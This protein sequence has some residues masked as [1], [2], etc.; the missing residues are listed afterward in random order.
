MDHV[1][2]TPEIVADLVSE[3][4]GTV[5]V[6]G[7]V[8]RCGTGKTLSL[9]RWMAEA[10]AQGSLRVAY[11]D[12]HTLLASDKVEID[13]GGQVRGAAVGHYPMFDLNGADV[14]IVDEPL[15]NRELV[16]R[17]LAHVEPDGGAFM[18]RLL[19]LP[20]QTE[21]AITS[22]GIPRSALRLFSVARRPL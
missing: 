8:G 12:G 21:E 10:R 1:I 4:L 19:I 13:F 20:L 15:Q 22:L 9:K 3:C 17:V 11:A 16:E 7:I 18:H 2:M 14:V 6:L 5:K